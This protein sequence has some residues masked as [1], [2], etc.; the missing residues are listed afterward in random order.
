MLV[1]LC[2]PLGLLA[3][4]LAGLLGIG[5]GLLIVPALALL[6][7]LVGALPPQEALPAAVATSLASILVTAPA[8]AAAH[9]LRGAVAW[10]LAFSLAPGL[11]LG[12]GAAGAGAGSL[13]VRLLALIVAGFF[14]YAAWRLWCERAA[15]AKTLARGWLLPAG[16]GIGAISALVGIGGGTLVVPLLLRLGLG[17][18][19][20]I[21]TAAA[22]GLAIAVGGTLGWGLGARGEAVLWWEGALLIGLGSAIAAPFGAA[23]AHRAPARLLRRL[24]AGFL[25]L[26][27]A[28]IGC[29][30]L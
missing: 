28:A 25:L 7:P 4:L 10:P 30:H 26:S 11:A 9:A 15:R 27:A 1:L 5:G 17:I 2:L 19:R 16:V 29:K 23:L 24:F 22:C 6:L 3:G 12:A 13:P 8:S 18:H 20:A 14:V 21:G